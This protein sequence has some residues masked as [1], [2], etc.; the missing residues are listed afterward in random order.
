MQLE[1]GATEVTRFMD[2]VDRRTVALNAMFTVTYVSICSH[3]S[4]KLKNNDFV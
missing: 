4:E 2:F 1:I 3:R